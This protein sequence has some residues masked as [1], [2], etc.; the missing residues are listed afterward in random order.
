MAGRYAAG[1]QALLVLGVVGVRS[2]AWLLR[3]R[4]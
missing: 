4:V 1:K 2:A 3:V